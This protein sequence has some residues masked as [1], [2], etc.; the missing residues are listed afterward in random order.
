MTKTEPPIHP[1]SQADI[2]HYCG[3]PIPNHYRDCQAP[4][5]NPPP[6]APCEISVVDDLYTKESE[7]ER[8]DYWKGQCFKYMDELVEVQKK[9][10]QQA[11]LAMHNQPVPVSG[12]PVS[13]E[14]CVAALDAVAGEKWDG[15]ICYEPHEFCRAILDAAGVKYVE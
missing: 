12:I 14:R 13:L 11:I 9:V 6:D 15:N 5:T 2:C 7:R 1:S 4:Q 8:G 10:D 3:G